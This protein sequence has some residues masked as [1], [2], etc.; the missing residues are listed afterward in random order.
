MMVRVQSL[1]P[2][3]VADKE[4]PKLHNHELKWRLHPCVNE[5]PKQISWQPAHNNNHLVEPQQ[6]SVNPKKDDQFILL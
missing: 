1:C 4:N 5:A 3:A 6:R 2:F